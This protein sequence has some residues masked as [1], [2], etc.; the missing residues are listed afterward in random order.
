MKSKSQRDL[1]IGHACT[2]VRQVSYKVHSHFSHP[3]LLAVGLLRD[4]AVGAGVA[5]VAVPTV[6]VGRAVVVLVVVA[7]VA[8]T[9]S[10]SH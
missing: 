8:K 6:V 7:P 2:I 5:A 4:V 10:T 9:A 1:Q 3:N